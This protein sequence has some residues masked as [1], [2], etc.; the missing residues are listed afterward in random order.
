MNRT[1]SFPAEFKRAGVGG[2]TDLRSDTKE[3]GWISGAAVRRASWE[4]DAGT[5]CCF[6]KGAMRKRQ[7][8]LPEGATDQA[9]F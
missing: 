7:E 3:C 4:Q 6:D 5:W 2:E 9:D 8:G 1:L